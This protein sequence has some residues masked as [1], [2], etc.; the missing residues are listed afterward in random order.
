[1]L[2]S[3]ALLMVLTGFM[4]SYFGER[5]LIGP[6][7]AIDAPLVKHRLARWV[8]R[9]AWHLTTPLMWFMALV[10]LRGAQAPATMDRL[11][12]T[13]IGVMW[14]VAGLIDAVGSRGKHIGWPPITLAGL[15][16]LLALE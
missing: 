3:A 5:R 12:V 10:L 6:L 4:H 7:L 8:I 14:L 1:M 2:T 9:F 13:I 15:L 11:L 16:T